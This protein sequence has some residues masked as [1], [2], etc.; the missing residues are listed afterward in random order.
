M[1]DPSAHQVLSLE[2][3]AMP[4]FP[5]PFFRKS[6]G[7]WYVQIGAVQHNL[8]P[9]EEAAFVEYHR[10]MQQPRDVLR[11]KTTA[12]SV[13]AVLDLFLEWTKAHRAPR[14]F[15]WYQ[16]RTQAFVNFKP[17]DGSFVAA[18]LTVDEMKPFHVQQW[19]DSHPDWSNSHKRNGMIAMQRAFN[20]A[21]RIG[22]IDKSPI[23]YLEKPPAGR[24]EQVIKPDEYARMLAEYADQQFRDVLAFCWETGA[25]PQE[26]R[27]IEARHLDLSRSRVVLPPVEAKGKKRHRVIY[28][29]QTALAI[30]RRLSCRW[31]EGP[32]FRNRNDR[33][34]TS[35]SFNCRFCRLQEKLGTKYALYAFRHTFANRL[36]ESGIDALTVST[37]LGHV[38]GTMLARVYSHLDQ[39]ATYLRD[40]LEK[41]TG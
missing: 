40:A 14:T 11:P 13:V 41:A 23:R 8:G 16:E 29:N 21:E 28:L 9:D 1:A 33:P 7:L 39:N 38:D 31:P 6:R 36:L 12:K 19:V 27:V 35:V 18:D 30:V 2:G 24:R 5:K 22:H 34:W 32:M 4:H 20:W 3:S 25:R 17:K 26:V 15:E 37:L 10:L